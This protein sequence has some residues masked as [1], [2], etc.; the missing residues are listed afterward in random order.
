MALYVFKLSLLLKKMNIAFLILL[1]NL[2]KFLS[3]KLD[4][5]FRYNILQL[6]M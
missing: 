3:N 2:S 6:G 1:L 5:I 4:L